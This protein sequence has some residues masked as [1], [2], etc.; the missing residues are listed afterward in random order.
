M[1]L[2]LN[3]IALYNIYEWHRATI[4]PVQAFASLSKNMLT[5]NPMAKTRAGRHT[6]A[7]FELLE[8]MTRNYTKPSFGI[9]HTVVD[10]EQV[11]VEDIVV[12]REPF[13]NLRYFKRAG[14][15]ER[16]P[17][18]LVVAPMSGHHATL[19]RGTVEALLPH[20]EV[21]ITDWIDAR[22]IPVLHGTFDLDD[23]I[24]M[25]RD[26]IRFIGR[27][28]HVVAVCQPS[29]PV[30][31]AVSLM[32]EDDDPFVPASMTLMG[33][34]IDTRVG[35]TKVNELATQKPLEWFEHNVI[36]YVPCNY[37]G[38]M[39][40]VYPGFL[41]LSGFMTM[42]LDRHIGEHVKLFNHLVE[43]DG[44]NAEMHR[45][46]YDE[47]LSVADITAE[48]YLM[49]IDKVFQR[50][51][52]PKGEFEYRGR[53]VQPEYITETSLLCVEGE[54]DDISGV[55]QTKAAMDLCSNLAPE[56]KHYHLQ[57]STGHYGIFN[58]RKYREQIVPVILEHIH[59]ANPSVKLKPRIVQTNNATPKPPTTR[60]TR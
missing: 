5:F 2:S 42:N 19:L 1:N 49:T 59:A 21:Y 26:C 6:T 40:P 34:P 43:G 13:C 11:A 58:G 25:V 16:T 3:N 47:Y 4:A 15:R 17:K 20:A 9:T 8:R 23:Y 7:G 52:L 50:H 57:P 22:E 27:H 51:C 33:G 45:K 24:D 32:S 29:V 44:E 37:T 31:A 28:V 10:G 12:M 53:L 18:I 55:G 46:F 38:F 48:F 60:K 35:V 30:M 39:R 54:L 14:V 36:T 41:Q 56:K